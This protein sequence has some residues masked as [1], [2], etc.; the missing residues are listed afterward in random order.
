MVAFELQSCRCFSMI[1]SMGFSWI[2]TR[3]ITV[4]DV[5]FGYDGTTHGCLGCLEK[6]ENAA[7]RNVNEFLSPLS[8]R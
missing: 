4:I 5:F 1:Q 2:V 3:D 6:L 8:S 7:G